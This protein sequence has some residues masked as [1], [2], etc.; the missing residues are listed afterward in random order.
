MTILREKKQTSKK[1]VLFGIFS[2][3][4]FMVVF[5]YH[6]AFVGDLFVPL[7][8]ANF[9]GHEFISQVASKVAAS[10]VERDRVD[11]CKSFEG[12]GAFDDDS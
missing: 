10:F 5:N 7:S 4:G 6:I 12:F 8:G 1:A 9:D 3:L 2:Y 11:L